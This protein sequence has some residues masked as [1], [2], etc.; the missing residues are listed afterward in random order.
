MLTKGTDEEK[1]RCKKKKLKNYQNFSYYTK[2]LLLLVSVI[3]SFY[4]G[5]QNAI[6]RDDFLR[7]ITD[8]ENH[9]IRD[10]INRLFIHVII[11]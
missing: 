8:V 7:I 2:L 5:D 3:F 1:T 10:N 9:P 6:H 4:A 11:K